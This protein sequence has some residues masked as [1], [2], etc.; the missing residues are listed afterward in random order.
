[1]TGPISFAQAPSQSPRMLKKSEAETM[2]SSLRS[3]SS[4]AEASALASLRA[5][6]EKRSAP[7]TS[8]SG[9]L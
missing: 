9:P 7:R 1:M 2:A 8:T 5:G 3:I 4:A 6:T